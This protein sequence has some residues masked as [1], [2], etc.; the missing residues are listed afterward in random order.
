[1]N[2]LE[3]FQ[4]ANFNSIEYNGKVIRIADVLPVTEIQQY[5]LV[6]E[7]TNSNW[8]QGIFVHS[9]KAH[10]LINNGIER[11]NAFHLWH[12]ENPT[13]N[14]FKILKEGITELKIWNIWRIDKGPMVYGSNGGAVYFEEIE[15]GK[16]YFCNDGYP[17]D[18]FNDLIFTIKWE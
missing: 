6:F 11:I 8:E 15:N 7:E 18:D 17:D 2:F 14:K 4:K 1:M 13:I 12:S 9:K 3:L 5:E 16:K 10:F